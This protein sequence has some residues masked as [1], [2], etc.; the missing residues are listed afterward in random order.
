MYR[1]EEEPTGTRQNRKA[2]P[3]QEVVSGLTGPADPFALGVSRS[4]HLSLLKVWNPRFARKVER[5][6]VLLPG[7]LDA[8][9][10]WEAI[11]ESPGGWG[12]DGPYRFCSQDRR[13]CEL[14]ATLQRGKRARLGS[15]AV[16]VL[17][18]LLRIRE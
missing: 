9:L 18:R 11:A 4:K 10:C 15:F 2:A 8:Q 1:L 5:P 16:E 14:Q 13:L 7:G 12:G 6:G 3:C 17:R